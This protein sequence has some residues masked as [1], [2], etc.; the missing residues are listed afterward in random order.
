MLSKELEEWR[1][2]SSRARDWTGVLSWEGAGQATQVL[3]LYTRAAKG[4]VSVAWVL[5]SQLQVNES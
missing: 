4:A 3:L 5:Y 1:K 2:E